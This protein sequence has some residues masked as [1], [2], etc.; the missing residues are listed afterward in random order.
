MKIAVA[1]ATGIVGQELLSILEKRKFPIS[2]CSLF[3]SS[4]SKGKTI[5]FKGKETVVQSI[6]EYQDEKYDLAFFE[7]DEDITREYVPK[8]LKSGTTV[9]DLSST[10]R[11]EKNVPLIVSVINKSLLQNDETNLIAG[12]N[13]VVTPLVVVLYH[14]SRV[15]PLKRV[16]VTTFQSVSGAGQKGVVA[17]KGEVFGNEKDE[18]VPV[19]FPKKIAFNLIPQVPQKNA[20][21][22]DG[23]TREEQKIILETRKILNEPNLRITTTC[24]RV[25]VFKCHS[26]S[27]NVELAGDVELDKIKAH[28]KKS[29][30]VVLLDELD[31]PTPVDCESKDPVF[32]GRLRRDPSVESGVNLW[33]VGDNIRKGA[34]LNAVQIAEILIRNPDKSGRPASSAG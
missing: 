34:A 33:I 6:D 14:I 10:Y 29:D 24:V 11:L 3:A 25:P 32:I 18:P 15:V 19:V 28:L 20:F 30:G 27:V 17:L 23:Y 5:T 4:R 13:C 7:L 2:Y 1:G 12:P 21:L 8:F 9:V 26:M 31:Y 22:P 16:V